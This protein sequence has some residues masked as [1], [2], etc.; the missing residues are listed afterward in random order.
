MGREEQERSNATA[1]C[2]GTPGVFGGHPG[3]GWSVGGEEL[4]EFPRR[5]FGGWSQQ[6]WV[7]AKER[8]QV[9]RDRG[10]GLLK[11]LTERETPVRLL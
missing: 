11:V 6:R 3:A 2:I 7:R 9:F 5:L 10:R 1:H 4:D 8:V